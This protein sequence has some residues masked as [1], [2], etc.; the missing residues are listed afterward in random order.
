M[1]VVN[2][3]VIGNV[4]FNNP[5]YR[6]RGYFDRRISNVHC[7]MFCF[8]LSDLKFE[9]VATWTDGSDTYIY[10]DFTG[11]G[12][13]SR[14]D[15]YR[16]FVSSITVQYCLWYVE[17]VCCEWH[18][19]GYIIL[20]V[21]FMWFFMAVSLALCQ[22]NDCYNAVEATLGFYSLAGIGIP[23]INLRRSNDRLSFIMGIP[24]P[25]R[26]CRLSE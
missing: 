6:F 11:P 9:C 3:D 26:R 15:R 16:C 18:W 2:S 24:K 13:M 5:W 12:V 17:T 21:G 22:S 25:G 14:D 19:W 23:I 8:F 10:G 7:I 1:D 4:N 20:D